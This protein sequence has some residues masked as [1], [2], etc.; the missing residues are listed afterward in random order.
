MAIVRSQSVITTVPAGLNVPSVEDEIR[1]I[2][3][4][5]STLLTLLMGLNKVTVDNR[6]FTIN[7]QEI[8]ASYVTLTNVTGNNLTMST[9]DVKFVRLGMTLILNSVT[10]C[11]VTAVNYTT[12]VVGV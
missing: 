8:D 1:N 4:A 12:G 5:Q 9:D 2:R 10:T 11:L 7:E 3:P 6:K